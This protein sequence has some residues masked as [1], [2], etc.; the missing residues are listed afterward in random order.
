MSVGD[1]AREATCTVRRL[2][3]E[4]PGGGGSS[5]EEEAVPDPPVGGAD[6]PLSRGSGGA[7]ERFGM[8]GGSA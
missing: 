6:E 1:V 3:A 2:N 5:V 4:L 7:P 8:I